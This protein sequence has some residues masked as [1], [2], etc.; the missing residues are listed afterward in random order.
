M[1]NVTPSKAYAQAALDRECEEVARTASGRNGRLNVAAYKLGQ[2]VS[3]R[4]L[5]R[6]AV[7]R[8]L[9]EAAISNGYVAK[10][11]DRQTRATIRSG[12]ERGEFEPRANVSADLRR[13]NGHA[14][15]AERIAADA[16]SF[17]FP[18]WTSPDS[19]GKPPLIAVGAGAPES[20]GDEER[21]HVYRRRGQTVR[22]KIKRRSGGFLNA[23]RVRRPDD[24]AIGWQ[25]R[26]PDGFVPVAYTGPASAPH[27]F[28]P[29]NR[30]GPLFWP[31]GEKDV[32]TLAKAGALAFTFGGSSDVP[33][34]A[35][36]LI[37]GRDLIILADNDEPGR[38]CAARKVALARQA[39]A[40]AVRVMHFPELGPG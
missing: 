5:E 7:E 14:R 11:G 29:E 10:N 6:E 31:E 33:G 13:K 3:A 17:D 19:K 35:G 8:R 36:S 24:G 25:F 40:A 26:K 1:N 12:I 9:Y 16:A 22:I 20:R 28:D 27:P 15:V 21:R 38:N 34:E 18:V 2:L 30:S 23:Y 39:G 4:C 32:D 37:A